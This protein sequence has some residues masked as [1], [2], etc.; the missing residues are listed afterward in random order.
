[1]RFHLQAKPDLKLIKTHS[2]SCCWMHSL[3]HQMLIHLVW[4]YSPKNT[5]FT[6]KHILYPW[7]FFIYHETINSALI[8]LGCVMRTGQII[9]RLVS[10]AAAL[11]RFWSIHGIFVTSKNVEQHQIYPFNKR[12]SERAKR[13]VNIQRQEESTC[14]VLWDRQSRV[15]ERRHTKTQRQINSDAKQTRSERCYSPGHTQE[16]WT[17]KSSDMTS[18]CSREEQQ[19]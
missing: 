17:E 16:W 11:F 9:Q 3:K 5:P 1:M 15:T 7:V 4:K 19:L 10:E 2:P 12:E 6:S 18:I 8:L 13:N 14:S